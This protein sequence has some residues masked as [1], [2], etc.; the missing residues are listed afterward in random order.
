MSPPSDD[1]TLTDERLKEQK[2]VADYLAAP[3]RKRRSYVVTALTQNSASE[4]RNS[5]EHFLRV[6]FKAIAITHARNTE[7]LKKAFSRQVVMLIYDDEFADLQLGMEMINGLKRKKS[8][9]SSSVLFLTKHPA[10]LIDAYNKILL[11]FHESDDYLAID[12]TDNN[13]LF[14]KI[15]SGLTSQ[16]KRRSRRYKVD[17]PITFYA[18]NDDKEYTGKLTDLSIHGAMMDSG[19]NRLFTQDEQ[20]KVSIPASH[21][22]GTGEGDFLKISARVRRVLIGGNRAGISFEHVSDKQLFR[23]TSYLS[24][25]VNEQVTKAVLNQRLKS[26]R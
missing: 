19:A 7:E 16:F 20:I 1:A 14:S 23:L 18:L 22:L 17:V 11:P 15:K 24:G 9:V 10:D 6:N 13:L 4:F 21:F 25:L 12:R 2:R 8:A 3:R 26:V 5:I